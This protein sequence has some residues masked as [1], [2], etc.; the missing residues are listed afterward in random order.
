MRWIP[1]QPVELDLPVEREA[2]AGGTLLVLWRRRR[3]IAGCLGLVL[4]ASF[5][6]ATLTPLVYTSEA[7][8]QVDFGRE[9]SGAA[10]PGGG[11]IQVD[12]NALVEGEA[13]LI[14]SQA[15]A[16]RVITSLGLD[17]DPAFAAGPGFLSRLTS[18]FR[19]SE[20][21]TDRIA[22]L[23]ATR[24]LER[25]SV[26]NDSRSY[27]IAVSYTSVDPTRTAE[28]AN[29]FAEEYLQARMEGSVDAA[30]RTTA[31]LAAQVREARVALAAA[32]ENIVS[33]RSESGFVEVGA[34]GGDVSQNQFRDAIAQL[35][36]ARLARVMAESRLGKAR[37]T[38]KAG[39][40]PEPSESV[41]AGILQRL[42]EA[43]ALAGRTVAETR[44]AYGAR[45]PNAERAAAA[46]AAVKERLDAEV[47]RILS[48]L[49]TNV[50]AMQATERSL[51]ARVIQLQRMAMESKAREARIKS[52]QA[53]AAA[54][55]E[56]LRT[57]TENFERTRALSELKP[58]V[59]SIALTA[60]ATSI[61]SGPNRL[62]IMILAAAGGASLGATLALLMERQDR[63][64]RDAGQ[65]EGDRGPRCLATIPELSRMDS[66]VEWAL[67]FDAVRRL[68]ANLGLFGASAPGTVLVASAGPHEGKSVL[69]VALAKCLA[70][71]GRSVLVIDTSPNPDGGG[72]HEAE[73]S[74]E[75]LLGGEES[76]DQGDTGAGIVLA[77]RRL[78]LAD[79]S[80]VFGEAFAHLILRARERYDTILIEAPP[81]SLLSD[82][83]LAA[84]N[85]DTVV[86]VARWMN[87]RRA[88]AAAAFEAL[89]HASAHVA[90]LVLTR[91]VEASSGSRRSTIRTG[92]IR[93][94]LAMARR[95]ALESS[96]CAS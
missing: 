10:S 70:E 32:E 27:L 93:R 80:P 84:D 74:L 17:R 19:A 50:S 55:R 7:L 46:H 81:I 75:A 21:D 36:N 79:G 33:F 43:E 3:F 82:A 63:G 61:P 18:I 44:I 68:A 45:H 77:R 49:E 83:I 31:W 6:V 57:L 41:D 90:G 11:G 2:V 40:L 94:H 88:A 69:V 38:V 20:V 8:V 66:P 87:T 71:A 64:F 15:V 14:R 16:R 54:Q 1:R 72:R 29:A 56:R 9:Q 5:V 92:Y 96:P 34:E 86:L 59:A 58:T 67:F 95:P 28:I 52:L 13:R 89:E 60:K 51:Q 47:K 91:T 78:G 37:D 65:I 76:L 62:L 73:T 24:L 53:E 12:P 4:L 22:E 35:E 48:S 26:K 23:I 25:L 30:R 42:A 39:Y 85:A